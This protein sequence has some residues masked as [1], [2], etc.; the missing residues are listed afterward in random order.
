MSAAMLARARCE[1]R[2]RRGGQQRSKGQQAQRIGMVC[3]VVGAS[4]RVGRRSA[5]CL[6]IRWERNQRTG[7]D[8]RVN[9]H[10]II[11]QRG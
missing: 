11:V 2:G 5:R 6:G 9:S 10:T 7:G 4:E 3:T 1:A 8:V